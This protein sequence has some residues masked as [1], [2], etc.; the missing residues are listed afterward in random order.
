[1]TRA[2]ISF[3]GVRRHSTAL[4]AVASLVTVAGLGV[5]TTQVTLPDPCPRLRLFVD[6]PNPP[7]DRQPSP[8]AYERARTEATR[9]LSLVQP[10]PGARPLSTNPAGTDPAPLG[11][12]WVRPVACSASWALPM[13]YAEATTW[14][15]SYTPDR[16]KPLGKGLHVPSPGRAESASNRTYDPDSRPP[17]LLADFLTLSLHRGPENTGV[18]R[19]DGIAAPYVDLP[20][21]D[22]ASEDPVRVL[23]DGPCP[24]TVVPYPAIVNPGPP[25]LDR[26][27][28]P[29]DETPD[30]GL[31]CYY[32]GDGLW[33]QRTLD[34]AAA[35]RIARAAQRVDL[36]WNGHTGPRSGLSTSLG[37]AMLALSYPG[38]PDV[39]VWA[40]Y[41]GTPLVRNG[42]VK[43]DPDRSRFFCVLARANPA[44]PSGWTQAHLAP[45]D[46]LC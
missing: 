20:Q 4:L 14:L 30:G 42:H 3:P 19:A 24:A 45:P 39:D 26:A 5:L 25:D 31:I 8:E 2:D 1:M 34:R 40:A 17:R 38:R 22:D 6:A 29:P 32:G 28:V 23:A 41:P 35:G 9:L 37:V 27:L 11:D 46:D 15:R 43:N 16:A 7:A 18:L 33:G 21:R 10:P 44:P 13:T 36:T 12:L